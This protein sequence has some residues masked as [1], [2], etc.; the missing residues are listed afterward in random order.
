[1]VCRSPA[2]PGPRPDPACTGR[3]MNSR[4][5]SGG[6]DSSVAPEALREALDH[7][8]GLPV[9]GDALR[10]PPA[11]VQDGGVVAAAEGAADRRQRL[12]GQLAREVHGDLA[13]PGHG[14]SAAG[15]Q[16]L[17]ERDSERGTRL[18]LYLAHGA[19]GALAEL[20]VEARQDL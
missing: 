14:R 1:M 18:L 16:Q 4:S 7:V 2:R 15:G 9:A 8:V 10:G 17:V 6:P 3:W 20:R 13:R 19:R 5:L 11:G 12:V